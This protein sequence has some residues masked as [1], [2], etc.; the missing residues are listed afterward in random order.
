MS[1]QKTVLAFALGHQII[2][3]ED[4]EEEQCALEK[5]EHFAE[6]TV[7]HFTDMQ[8]KQHFRMSPQ[9]FE[10]FLRK[11]HTVAGHDAVAVGHPEIALEKEAMIALWCLANME[12]FRSVSDRFGV[13]KS[14][15]WAVL[16]RT[17]F[18]ILKLNQIFNIISWP[19]R[20]RAF[21]IAEAFREINGFEGVIG[22]IEGSHIRILPPKKYPNSYCNRKNFHSIL[23]QGVCDHKKLFTHVYTGEPGSIHDK[24]L[25]EKSDLYN[26][27]QQGVIN[28]SNNSHLLGDLAY[29]LTEYLMVGF[30]NNGV[31]TDRKISIPSY[32][33]FG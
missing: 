5:V 3:D 19:S 16:Y 20:Q 6:E 28:F 2:F 18:K 4:D 11:L 7:P 17:C 22:C 29:K 24:R 8:F 30:K 25:F 1:I 9:T 13:S 12:S 15:C 26:D 33:K 21:D 23:L 10:D 14:T 27:I 32:H 31:L